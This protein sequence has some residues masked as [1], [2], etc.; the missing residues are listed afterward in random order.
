[1]PGQ[2]RPSAEAPQSAALTHVGPR[3]HAE[4][5][6]A[7][8]AWRLR[9]IWLACLLALAPAPAGPV[10]LLVS[11]HATGAAA[12]AAA[13]VHD[14][15]DHGISAG[16]LAET[17]PDRHC[18]YCQ[19]A[20]TRLGAVVGGTRLAAP[21]AV[22]VDWP[23]PQDNVLRTRLRHALPARAPPPPA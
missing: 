10:G 16:S 14:A 18:L 20:S 3:W 7:R 12:H 11:D 17:D 8:L 9:A 6:P 21:A 13:P 4:L 23:A 1:M 19:F 15:S 22:E 5:M 2:Y